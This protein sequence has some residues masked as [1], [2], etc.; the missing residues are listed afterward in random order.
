MDKVKKFQT[1]IG[2][3]AVVLFSITGL[4][5]AQEALAPQ[6]QPEMAIG[7][8]VSEYTLGKGD[9]VKIE[10]RNQPEFT[11][12]FVVG[13]DGDIQYEFAGDIKAEGLTKQEL[14][15]L[16][17]EKLAR[18]VKGPEV[19]VIVTHYLSKFV[20]VLGEVG[21]PGKY[22]MKG[23]MVSLREALMAAGLPTRSA[24]L[25]RV[26]V[27]TPDEVKPIVAKADIYKLLYEGKLEE[28]L[29]LAPGDVVV[30]SAT[31]PT[32][33]NRALTNMLAPF[34]KAASAY[35]LYDNV[36]N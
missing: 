12:N 23:D 31:I 5:F 21:Q 1:I 32:E 8:S 24:A 25:R 15:A 33:I 14:Q 3:L 17:T 29:D 34:S 9:R 10:V 22:P 6:Y 35:Y 7:E 36:G 30:V 16:I 13:P 27:I 18:Y 28:N 20:Y 2:F 4:S 19:S 11:G 26:W